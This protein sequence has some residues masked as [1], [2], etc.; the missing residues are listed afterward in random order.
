MLKNA[1]RTV[2]LPDG[3]KVTI[4]T[5]EEDWWTKHNASG[6]TFP[7]NI[8]QDPKNPRKRMNP[9]RLQELQESIKTR[10]V[11]QPLIVTPRALAP[12][13]EV[14][15]QDRQCFFLAVSGNRRQR[16]AFEAGI[17]AVPIKIAVYP[18]EKEHRMDASLLNKGQDDLTP[19]EEGYEMV[20]LRVLGWKIRE[21]S[22]AFGYAEPQLYGRMNLTKL[23]PDLQKLLDPEP[24]RRPLL[25]ITV[26]GH[27]GGV[28]PPSHDELEQLLEEYAKD[29]PREEILGGLELEELDENQLRFALQ[30]LL[31]VVIKKRGLASNQAIEF[32]KDRT[33]RLRASTGAPGRKPERFQPRRRKDIFDSMMASVTSSVVIDWPVQEWRRIFEN[34]SHEEVER[35]IKELA[36]VTQLLSG[37]SNILERI[38]DSK[39]PS[40]PDVARFMKQRALHKDTV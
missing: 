4:S 26:G 31:Y 30:K 6:Y 9:L 20:D 15:P 40:H 7:A 39:R 28:H 29:A 23:H 14:P 19:L 34:A 12:W 33:L 37:I 2:L 16:C 3:E 17:G 18:S 11:R 10:G 22:S 24:P 35:Y 1:V 25:P 27:L 36:E 38:R 32:I 8:A 5:V 13:A 21:L